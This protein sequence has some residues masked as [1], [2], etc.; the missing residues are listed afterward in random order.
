MKLNE[1][2][3]GDNVI[4]NNI[5]CNCFGQETYINSFKEHH[6]GKK[7]I[8]TKIQDG[9]RL[10]IRVS[11]LARYPMIRD[12]WWHRPECLDLFIE[13]FN[14]KLIVNNVFGCNYENN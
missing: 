10:Q 14:Y 4:I 12:F 2:H 1:I 13:G 3:V 8:V 11:Y 7:G 9:N 6:L 5:C